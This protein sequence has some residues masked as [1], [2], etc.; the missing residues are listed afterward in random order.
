[1]TGPDGVVTPE[2]AGLTMALTPEELFP[3]LETFSKTYANADDLGDHEV[4][5]T[6]TSEA[7]EQIVKML[8]LN[9]VDQID[10]VATLTSTAEPLKEAGQSVL[11]SVDV[12]E[13]YGN[14]IN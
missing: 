3:D 6:I 14:R 13:E 11:V 1:M 5:L 4:T 10:P 9:L 8:T 12:V 7:G 2:S